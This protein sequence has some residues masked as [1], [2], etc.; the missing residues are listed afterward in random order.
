MVT[1]NLIER[2]MLSHYYIND[3]FCKISKINCDLN[4]LIVYHFHKPLKL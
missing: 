1:D 3:N 2:A 4:Q